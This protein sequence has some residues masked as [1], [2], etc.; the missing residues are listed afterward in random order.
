MSAILAFLMSS[1]FRMIWGEVTDHLKKRRE[2]KQE[3]T[4]MRLQG[5]LDKERHEQ[6]QAAIR[7]QAE[8]NINVVR[9]QSQ[10]DKEKMDLQIAGELEKIEAEAF[11]EASVQVN[12]M[13]GIFLIDFWN[14]SI[15]PAAATISL[16]LWVCSVYG[17][18]L[19]PW[20]LELISSILGFYFADRSLAK[21]GK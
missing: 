21:R 7:L 8:L 9:V 12:K 17:F 18:K 4:L 14:Q 5:D 15:R 2:D 20:D 13:T 19:T 11:R 16:I 10:A 6:Q 3:L 1:A